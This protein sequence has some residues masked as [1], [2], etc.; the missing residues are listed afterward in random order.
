MFPPLPPFTS[1]TRASQAKVPFVIPPYFSGVGGAGLLWES[2]SELRVQFC[3]QNYPAHAVRAL[4][5]IVP[6]DYPNAS[7]LSGTGVSLVTLLPDR[8]NH[9]V[10]AGDAAAG[11][12]I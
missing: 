8:S 5:F 9:I 7:H 12:S 1:T 4:L 11:A 3:K 6:P 2:N 10:H